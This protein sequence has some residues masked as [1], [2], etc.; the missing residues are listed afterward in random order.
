NINNNEIVL[1]K[2]RHV[3]TIKYYI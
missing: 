1:K 2:L 3:N